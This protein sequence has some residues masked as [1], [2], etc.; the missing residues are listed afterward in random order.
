MVDKQK[1]FELIRQI[2]TV[3]ILHFLEGK[4]QSE[5]ASELNLSTSKVNRLITQGRKMGMI[6]I[7]IESPFQTLMDLERDL[8]AATSLTDAVVTPSIS[9]SVDTTLQQV[10]RAA[11]TSNSSQISHR[12]IV[13]S[14][15]PL[16]SRAPWLALS[17]CH[18]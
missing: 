16:K 7:D 13:G 14:P 9:G 4:K 2:H 6:K 8:A 3:L 18:S 10:G 1:D 17:C 15:R 5:I 12:A 11:A